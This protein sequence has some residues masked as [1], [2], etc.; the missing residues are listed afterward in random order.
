MSLFQKFLIFRHRLSSIATDE[1]QQAK[2]A[3]FFEL[4]LTFERQIKRSLRP[5]ELLAIWSL[6][7]DQTEVI[8]NLLKEAKNNGE[9]QSN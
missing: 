4:A 6:E 1:L 5:P 9:V 3:S 8:T 2:E 7:S